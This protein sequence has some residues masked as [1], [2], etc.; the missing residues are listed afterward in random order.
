MNDVWLASGSV[1]I[2]IDTVKQINNKVSENA[3]SNNLFCSG[4]GFCLI[5]LRCSEH[6][7]NRKDDQTIWH[8]TLR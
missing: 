1:N 5:S 8:D 6:I 4:F 2:F 7:S 3:F